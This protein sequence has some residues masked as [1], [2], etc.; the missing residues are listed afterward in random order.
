MSAQPGHRIFPLL[1]YFP[2]SGY[3]EGRSDEAIQSSGAAW[4]APLRSQ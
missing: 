4:I 1:G 3:C 2:L